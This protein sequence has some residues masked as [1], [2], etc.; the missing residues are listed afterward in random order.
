MTFTHRGTGN[1]RRP[2]LDVYLWPLLRHLQAWNQAAV[3]MAWV[4]VLMLEDPG[5]QYH[6]KKA[7][8]E[9]TQEKNRQYQYHNN[10]VK[11]VFGL[12]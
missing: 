5:F 8:T 11:D 12:I 1:L 3:W 9:K 7:E 4:D 10:F 2:T 6:V